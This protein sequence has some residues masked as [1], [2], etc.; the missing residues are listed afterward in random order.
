MLVLRDPFNQLIIFRR[1]EGKLLLD[2]LGNSERPM[3]T[4]Q[5][6]GLFYTALGPCNEL[7]TCNRTFEISL[8]AEKLALV[9]NAGSLNFT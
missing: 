7:G 4:T 5:A 1:T 8:E 6:E 2:S 3:A 9:F